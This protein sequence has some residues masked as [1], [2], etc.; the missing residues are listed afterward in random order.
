MGRVGRLQ[1][2]GPHPRPLEEEMA[3]HSS[4]LAWKIPW[5]RSLVGYSPWSHKELDTTELAGMCPRPLKF[6]MSFILPV[7]ALS[8]MFSSCCLILGRW[9]GLNPPIH[10]HLGPPNVIF[11]GQSFQIQL[12]S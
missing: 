1:L 9:S 4:I 6:P 8:S 3:T 5:Q 11:F 7:I 12:K 2:E 10:V